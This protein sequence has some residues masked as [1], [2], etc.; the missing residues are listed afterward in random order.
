MKEFDNIFNAELMPKI[1]SHYT[2]ERS[3]NQFK[4]LKSLKNFNS[5][6]KESRTIL[7]NRWKVTNY[8]NEKIYQNFI[9]CT[10]KKKLENI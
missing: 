8:Q 2:N 5:S 7:F 3:G 4:I 10:V 9:S 6:F 1:V